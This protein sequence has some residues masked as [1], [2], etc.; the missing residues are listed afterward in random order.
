MGR[1]YVHKA[2]TVDQVLYAVA[3]ITK[4]L[5]E[6]LFRWLVSR[7]NR[8]LGRTTR[9]GTAFIGILDIAG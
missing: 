1:D 2:Q 4:A 6:R 7:I 9:Q 5:Y 8:S 3:A